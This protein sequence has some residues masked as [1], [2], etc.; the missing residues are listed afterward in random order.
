MEEAAKFKGE[1]HLLFSMEMWQAPVLSDGA[2][3]KTD[4]GYLVF[5]EVGCLSVSSLDMA[6]SASSKHQYVSEMY[7]VGRYKNVPGIS[8]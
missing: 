1:S 6:R 4:N 5:F 3:P 8:L 2:Y 7:F